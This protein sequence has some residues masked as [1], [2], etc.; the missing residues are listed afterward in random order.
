[1]LTVIQRVAITMLL[2]KIILS[3][4]HEKLFKPLVA[5]KQEGQL[6]VLL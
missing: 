6:N 5:T 3:T 4:F 1:M 2:V